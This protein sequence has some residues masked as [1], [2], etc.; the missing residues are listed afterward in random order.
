MKVGTF[1][2]P[3]GFETIGAGWFAGC[4]FRKVLVPRTVR[5]IGE[6][7]FR[8]CP[9]LKSVEFEPGSALETIKSGAFADCPKL[10]SVSVPA[11]ELRVRLQK[12]DNGP[13]W[14]SELVVSADVR[15]IRSCPAFQH[16]GLRKVTFGRRS[17]LRTI[18]REAFAGTQLREFVAPPSLVEI[19]PLA[20]AGCGQLELVRLNEGLE[21]V[22]ESCFWG[23]RVA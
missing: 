18:G 1:A 7:A 11:G 3:S 4:G 6:N 2:I 13:F 21:R 23:T 8:G 5:E 15:E 19:G 14:T 20:F 10:S 9:R 22:E 12:G 16:F 17:A